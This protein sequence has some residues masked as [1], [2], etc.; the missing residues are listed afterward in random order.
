MSS[1]IG[2]GGGGVR[3]NADGPKPLGRWIERSEIWIRSGIAFK[4]VNGRGSWR[5]DGGLRLIQ[6][7]SKSRG[8]LHRASPLGAVGRTHAR[9]RT[10]A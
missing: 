8:C 1:K 9:G 2:H 4:V 10:D 7:N 3:L 6:V 5:R